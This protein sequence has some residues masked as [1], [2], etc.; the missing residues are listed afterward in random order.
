MV[1]SGVDPNALVC[2]ADFVSK[3]KLIGVR[4]DIKALAELR[5]GSGK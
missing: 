3:L 4:D 5:R 1:E 2:D